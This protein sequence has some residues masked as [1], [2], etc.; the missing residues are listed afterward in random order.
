MDGG[1]SVNFKALFIISHLL[2][3]YFT[4]IFPC[5][6]G[7]CVWKLLVPFLQT[8]GTCSPE[9]MA[10][11]SEAGLYAL[12]QR[13][14]KRGRSPALHIGKYGGCVCGEGGNCSYTDFSSNSS[15]FQVCTS[16]SVLWQFITS[17]P[18]GL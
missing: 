6:F 14:A 11:G 5:A 12:G 10:R 7:P 8:T 1:P 4:T 3:W 18:K 15:V 13:S 16:S 9:V 17:K 2:L